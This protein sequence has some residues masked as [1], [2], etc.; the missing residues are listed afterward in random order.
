MYIYIYAGMP[1]QGIVR[2]CRGQVTSQANSEPDCAG[3]S[4]VLPGR[5]REK[6]QIGL[7]TASPTN[8][9]TSPSTVRF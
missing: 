9:P 5:C 7:P 4:W 8:Y 6:S 1:F 2:P 3:G